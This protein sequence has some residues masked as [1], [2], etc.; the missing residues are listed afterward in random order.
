M[1][2]PEKLLAQQRS[3]LDSFDLLEDAIEDG[4]VLSNCAKTLQ[5]F[6]T[7]DPQMVAVKRTTEKLSKL[8]DS[9]LISGPTGTGKEILARSLHGERKGKF[10]PLNLC[11]ISPDLL[12]SEIFGH[13]QGSFTGATSN[14]VG[15]IEH[16]IGGTLFLDEIGECPLFIQAKLLR[17]L[18]EKKIRRVGDNEEISLPSVRI[19][20]ATH[21][22]LKSMVDKGE[23]REDLYYRLSTFELQTTALAQRQWDVALLLKHFKCNLNPQ[24]ILDTTNCLPGN[25]RQLQQIARRYQIFGEI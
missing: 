14:R 4:T 13:K 17:F 16:A 7:E 20:A 23:F 3:L 21:R 2:D 12:A 11:E 15:L 5:S 22:N 9:V 19:L 25:V 10:V 8:E 18:Q 6:L 1:K 24:K